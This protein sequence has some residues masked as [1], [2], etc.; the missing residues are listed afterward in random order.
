[1]V[2]DRRRFLAGLGG[3]AALAAVPLPAWGR[4]QRSGGAL[5]SLAARAADLTTLRETLRAGT[6]GPLGYRPVVAGPGEPHVVRGELAAPNANRSSTRSSLLCFVHLTDQH[7]IDVQS[8]T[9]VE[10]LDRYADGSCAPVPFASAHRPHEAAS[11]RIADAMLRRLRRVRVSPVTGAPIAAMITTGDNTD[12]QQLNELELFL[13]IMDGGS[14]TPQ[15]GDPD[16]YQGVQASGDL[17]YWHPEPSVADMYKTAYGFPSRKGFLEQAL[18]P[19]EAVGAGVGWF[20]CYGNHDGLAQGNVAG[21]AAFEAIGV[22]GTKVVG[23]PP[24]ANPCNAFTPALV[25]P[26]VPTTPD[27]RRRYVTRREWIQAHLDSQGLPLGHGFTPANVAAN[28]AYY[29]VDVGPLRFITLDTVNPGGRDAGSVG[30][31]QL[32]WLDAELTAADAAGRLV[33]L[34]SHHG[35]RSLNNEV[36]T[37]NPLDVE[38]S[39]LPR[40][41]AD[42]V[43]AVVNAHRSVIAWV[44]GHTHDNVIVPRGS[45]WDIGTAAHIDWPAQSRIV[46]VVDNQD[47]T[48]SI[49]T[50]MVDHDGHGVVGFARELGANDPQAGFAGGTGSEQDRNTELLVRHPFV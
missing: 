22:G 16:R 50:T 17:S 3:A 13:G 15:S 24:G 44:N 23:L 8:P 27:P 39:D 30:D 41:R 25:G 47:G 40:H 6:A 33:L 49:F 4:A 26:S 20:T 12:N 48:L 32:R 34:F 21:N 9:R 5:P 1:M 42:E 35:P 36:V 37:P 14:V 19:F 11:A 31:L 46:E 18:A 38:G 10:F 7:I 43:L 45:Y 28:T 29:A 2:L